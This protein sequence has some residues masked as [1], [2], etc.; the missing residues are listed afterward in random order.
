[1]L[2]TTALLKMGD[3]GLNKAYCWVT[4]VQRFTE[5]SSLNIYIYSLVNTSIKV[6]L[7]YVTWLSQHVILCMFMASHTDSV[8]HRNYVKIISSLSNF[9]LKQYYGVDTVDKLRYISYSEECNSVRKW[10]WWPFFHI[11][12]QWQCI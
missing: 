11:I 5:S 10:L 12:K 7:W 8:L 3:L 1:M 4:L 2:F 6:I 9:S